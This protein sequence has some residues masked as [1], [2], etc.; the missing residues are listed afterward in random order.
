MNTNDVFEE[1]K[2]QEEKIKQMELKLGEDW[3]VAVLDLINVPCAL[4]LDDLWKK[5]VIANQG[6]DYG[7]WEYP[8]QAYRHILIEYE[9]LKEKYNKL[10]KELEKTCQ[11]YDIPL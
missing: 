8:A 10:V 7:D 4:A 1:L 2:K 11:D 6:E 5:I 3:R 9:E